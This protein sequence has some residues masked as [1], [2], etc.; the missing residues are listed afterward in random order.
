MS[1]ALVWYNIFKNKEET[2]DHDSYREISLISYLEKL[3]AMAIN[4]RLIKYFDN[5]GI[6]EYEQAG[7]HK[8]YSTMDHIFVIKSVIHLYKHKRKKIIVLS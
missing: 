5:M 2:G 1:S 8:N 3:F 6:I 7:F 4:V